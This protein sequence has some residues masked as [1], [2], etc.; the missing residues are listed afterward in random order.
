VVVVAYVFLERNK[1]KK[2]QD[3]F[4]IE[5]YNLEFD[6]NGTFI[7]NQLKKIKEEYFELVHAVLKFK[8]DPTQDNYEHMMEE[9]FDLPQACITF[10][11][12]CVK[13]PE[14]LQHYNNIHIN[15]IH[16]RELKKGN[17]DK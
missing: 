2:E 12:S 7:T 10:I 11:K 16:E 17:G 13:S 14:E 9:L 6:F 3:T 4:E 5:M 1:F 8:Y 15:K